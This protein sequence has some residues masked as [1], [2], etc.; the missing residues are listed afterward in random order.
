MR[1]VLTGGGTG[2]H[3]YPAVAIGE[4]IIAQG[5]TV[6]M[7]GMR[8]GLEE[9]LVPAN[10]LPLTTIAAAPLPRRPSRAV[11]TMLTKNIRGVIAAWRL[12]RRWRP[13]AVIATGGYVTFPVVFAAW[14]MNR[15]RKRPAFLALLEPNAVAG[16]T[17]RLLTPL[18]DEVWWGIAAPTSDSTKSVHTGTPVRADLL[19]RRDRDEAIRSL[20][21]N[22]QRRIILVI[23]G[24]QGARSLNEATVELVSMADFPV[25][26]Q[27]LHLC[28]S[29]HQEAMQQRQAKATLEGRIRVRGYL[30][31]PADAYAVADI[32][33]ARAGASTLAELAALGKPAILVPYPFATND[34]QRYNAETF[35]QNGGASIISDKECTGRRL[36]E[37]LEHVFEPSLWVARQEAA[38]TLTNQHATA[39]VLNRLQRALAVK[40]FSR[41]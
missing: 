16:V 14:L 6:E 9:R 21:L 5:G 12:L 34:H 11:I 8:G 30:E 24:S 26:W 29:L 32:I 20:D 2:G 36:R 40:G 22:P 28:G 7:I 18:V 38:R 39:N 37:E 33:V 35:A 31:D 23:G 4:A 17:N 41:D 15:L 1:V 27:I 19:R 25:S 13:D 3:I 10:G